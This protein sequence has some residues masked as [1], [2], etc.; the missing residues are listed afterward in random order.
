MEL[1]FALRRKHCSDSYNKGIRGRRAYGDSGHA[2]GDQAY[3]ISHLSC[4]V[5]LPRQE[6][7]EM[8]IIENKN[9]NK[10]ISAICTLQTDI[11]VIMV[12]QEYTTE[13]IRQFIHR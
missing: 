3:C 6:V 7:D 9:D 4:D 12:W 5:N 11:F 8:K 2:D 13:N 10:F 1:R